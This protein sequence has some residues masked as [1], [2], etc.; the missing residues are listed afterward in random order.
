MINAIEAREKSKQR[1]DEIVTSQLQEIEKLVLKACED[2]YFYTSYEFSLK[3]ETE[4]VLVDLGYNFKNEGNSIVIEWDFIETENDVQLQDQK[5]VV[6]DTNESLTE[7][8]EC[9]FSDDSCD[10]EN[11][12]DSGSKTNFEATVVEDQV[13]DEADTYT[14]ENSTTG[15]AESFSFGEY[16]DI[17]EN[18]VETADTSEVV[19]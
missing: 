3:E 6:A 19:E 5:D 15:E 7:F 9:F 11:E 10:V 17:N 14:D 12:V 4:K 8:E 2:G 16:S 13:Q 1:L 18:T